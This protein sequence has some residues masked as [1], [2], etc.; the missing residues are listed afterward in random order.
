MDEIASA[1]ISLQELD[2]ILTKQKIRFVRISKIIDHG[3]GLVKL[4]SDYD[5]VKR[6][7]L[8]SQLNVSKIDSEISE[9]Q[10]KSSE[11]QE[12]LYGGSITNMR[13]LTAIEAE[14]NS[15][16]K[17]LIEKNHERTTALTQVSDTKESME[18]M[19]I[20]LD[21]RKNLWGKEKKSLAKEKSDIGKIFNSKL[22]N[23]NEFIDKIPE[24]IFKDYNR[25][26]KANNGIAI[27]TV[28]REICQ[29]CLVKLPVGD[30]DKMKNSS[31][32]VLCNSGKHFLTE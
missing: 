7:N 26:F 11:L 1:L 30:I 22:K 18:I 31:V 3:G 2:K 28:K 15:L 32:P 6:D 19:N 17:I 8:Q 24:D 5:I 29:G 13:E 4:K 14:Y 25:L 12:K 9:I 10:T 27:V 20:D 23:R 16:S 21:Q